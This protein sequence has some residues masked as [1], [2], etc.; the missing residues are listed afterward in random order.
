M[1]CMHHCFKSQH[2]MYGN[3]IYVSNSFAFH[4][5]YIISKCLFNNEAHNQ[6][7]LHTE[8]CQVCMLCLNSKSQ[9]LY[10]IYKNARHL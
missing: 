4:Y 8:H 7:Y 1:Q 2:T 9:K 3:R 6:L 5:S 10:V